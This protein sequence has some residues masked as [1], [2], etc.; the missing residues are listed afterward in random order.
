MLP[1]CH[2]VGKF[3]AKLVNQKLNTYYFFVGKP[4]FARTLIVL[5]M[6]YVLGIFSATC[7]IL[8]YHCTPDYS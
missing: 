1:R 2:L 3:F 5:Y 8:D 4:L 7:M 6:K